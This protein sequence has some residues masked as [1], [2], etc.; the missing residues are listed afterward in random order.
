MLLGLR[1]VFKKAVK[2]YEIEYDKKVVEI[3][4]YTVLVSGVPESLDPD[5]ADKSLLRYGAHALQLKAAACHMQLL[6]V[7]EP[8]RQRTPAGTLPIGTSNTRRKLART[9]SRRFTQ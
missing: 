3:S 5:T 8:R 9:P 1:F 4:D 6:Q 2:S 7:D